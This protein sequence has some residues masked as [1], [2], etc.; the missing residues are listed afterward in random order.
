MFHDLLDI[1]KSGIL[2]VSDRKLDITSNEWTVLPDPQSLQWS[3]QD[4]DSESTG[5]LAEDGKLMRQRVGIKR[6]L[7][8]QWS[9]MNQY[10]MKLILRA[11]V[12]QEGTG[13]FYCKYFD[14]Q[15]GKMRI[16]ECYVGDRTAPTLVRLDDN[17]YL[18]QSLSA[19]FIER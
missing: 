8:I 15:V 9:A 5:R 4:L 1:S 13:F 2:S 3:I 18:F 7:V 10:D 16:M 12:G 11:I 6:K 14:A 17:K 19:D